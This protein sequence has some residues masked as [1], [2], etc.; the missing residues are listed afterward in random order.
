MKKNVEFI[1]NERLGIELPTF[2]TDWELLTPEEQHQVIFK[3][4]TIRATIPDRIAA[5][6]RM[7]A[8]REG[9]LQV[10]DNFPIFCRLSAEISD[11]ASR[12]I[13]LNLWFRTQE[14]ATSTKVHN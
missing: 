8:E 7:I 13:D 5:L 1:Y 9:Q 14:E 12:V 3:W 6:E 11:Y 10:E 4:E 2:N